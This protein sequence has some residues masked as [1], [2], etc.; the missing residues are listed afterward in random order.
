MKNA[1]MDLVELAKRSKIFVETFN[2]N[3]AT[4]LT[5]LYT[6]DAELLV[7]GLPRLTGLGAVESFWK[8]AFSRGKRTFDKIE[9]VSTVVEGNLAVEYANWH[10]SVVDRDGN[11]SH[12]TGKNVLVWRRVHSEWLICLDIWNTP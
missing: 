5:T 7:P 8:T 3:D 11:V 2:R 10:L 4:S 9:P 1:D 12:E 6:K